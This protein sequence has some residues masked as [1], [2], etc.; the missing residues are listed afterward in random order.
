MASQ[1]EDGVVL[2]LGAP[3]AGKGTQ[4]RMLTELLGVP[5][6][7]SGDLLREHRQ[8]GTD[9]G[10]AAQAYMDRGDLVPDDLVV[11]MIAERLDRPDAGHG[12]LLDGFPRTLPQAE[13]LESRLRQR[14]SGIRVAVYVDVPTDVLIERLSGRWICRGCQASYHQ[15]FNPPADAAKCDLC[16]GEL[17]QRPDDTREVVT[18][19]VNVYLRDTLPVV[20][21]Y[22]S[23]GLLRRIDGNQSIDDVRSSLREALT[24]RLAT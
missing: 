17:Y 12:A 7:A 23:L 18:N 5:H 21:H 3:G 19:R 9:L 16:G 6:V 22:Q 4:A 1:S 8:Q 14:G 13:A 10:K 20:D 11:D 15:T 2:L 24:T